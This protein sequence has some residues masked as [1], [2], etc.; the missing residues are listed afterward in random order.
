M[1]TPKKPEDEKTRKG[2]DYELK[3]ATLIDGE[4]PPNPQRTRTESRTL[5]AENMLALQEHPNLPFEVVHYAA[6]PGSEANPTGARKIVSRILLPAGDKDRIVLPAAQVEGV[7]GYYDVEWR[8]AAYDGGERTGSVV[9]ATWVV[10]DDDPE[11]APEAAT[12]EDSE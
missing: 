10:E 9:I 2:P 8:D 7:V 6:K 1:A 5:L 12:N 3:P 11:A 4:L